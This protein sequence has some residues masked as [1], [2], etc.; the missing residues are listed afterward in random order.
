MTGSALNVS[1]TEPDPGHN[2]A[3]VTL[4]R[5]AAKVSLQLKK[6]D[7]VDNDVQIT[8]VSLLNNTGKT[9]LFP[10]PP[11]TA[12]V[13]PQSY[14]DFTKTVT[15]WTLTSTPSANAELGEIYL[16]ENITG[17]DKTNATQLEIEALYNNIQ[18]TYLVYLNENV[19]GMVNQ[20]DPSSSVTIPN[21]HLYS[22]RRGHHYAVNG[23][24]V[25]MGKFTGIVHST[26]VLPW[27]KLTSEVLFERVFTIFPHPTTD[28]HTY[29]AANPTDLVTFTFTLFN[30][31]G[32][33]WVAQLSNPYDFEF[34]T[35]AG[36]VS[37][38]GL[39]TEY[40]ISIKP[41]YPQGTT[42]RNTEFYI[43]VDGIEIPLLQSSLLIGTGNRI[44]I[45]QPAE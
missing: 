16:Y 9:T 40:T 43:T 34:S 33:T 12:S 44:E 27:E 20:G 22:L 10:T 32:A 6:G 5:I 17:G 2:E 28:S 38:G 30:P 14:W 29:T 35:S 25:N 15:P 19:S 41:R 4:T 3:Q 8:K 45:K 23:T 26:F 21:D 31:I 13:A 1:V 42:E 39:G 24:I 11:S 37:S 36:A 7:L 18:T